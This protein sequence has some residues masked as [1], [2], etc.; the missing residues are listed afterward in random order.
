M[1]RLNNDVNG[2]QQA[3]TGTLINLITNI[4]I[5]I[6]TLIV[7]ISMDWRLTL[8]GVIILPLLI[9][10]S[11]RTGNVLRQLTRQRMRLRAEMSA[12]M[13]ETLNV[14]G[15]LL[16]RYLAAEKTRCGDSLKKLFR[17]VI[18]VSKVLWLVSGSSWVWGWLA[19]LEQLSSI[20]W[21]VTW[22]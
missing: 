14:S 22:C 6:S 12:L 4:I 2:A 19:P 20:G 1:S 9:L 18:S 16:S 11:R 13:N 8:A 7:M 3:V 15:A 17:C 5:L 10:P 21:V